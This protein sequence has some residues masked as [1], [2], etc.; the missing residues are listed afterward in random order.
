MYW[1]LVNAGEKS[2]PP[3]YVDEYKK[4]PMDQV[5]CISSAVKGAAMAAL[6]APSGLVPAPARAEAAASA[7][8][9]RKRT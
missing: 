6:P 7:H 5:Y 9:L 4:P 2:L 1:P 8:W 3:R